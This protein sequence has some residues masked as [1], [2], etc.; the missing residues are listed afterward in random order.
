MGAIIKKITKKSWFYFFGAGGIAVALFTKLFLGGAGIVSLSSLEVGA[1]NNMMQVQ[2]GIINVANADTAGTGD[3]GS[4]GSGSSSGSDGSCDD[5]DG[6]S[7]GGS[8]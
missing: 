5:S 6:C 2:A 7:D 1:K 3:S 8:Y 4:D